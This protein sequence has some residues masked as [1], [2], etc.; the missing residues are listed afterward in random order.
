MDKG[1]APRSKS[2]SV[3]ECVCRDATS[4]RRA[5]RG[6]GAAASGASGGLP[7][8]E[9]CR[10]Q[11]PPRSRPRPSTGPR[12]AGCRRPGLQTSLKNSIERPRD[13]RFLGQLPAPR[14]QPLASIFGPRLGHG[15]STLALEPAGLRTLS[16]SILDVL[17]AS[18]ALQRSGITSWIIEHQLFC[19]QGLEHVVGLV[20]V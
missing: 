17:P 9:A 13:S 3:A 8:P 6:R 1:P 10:P 18:L 12:G 2:S 7:R 20:G 15:Y 14:R 16:H 4:H 5:R 19:G 11:R